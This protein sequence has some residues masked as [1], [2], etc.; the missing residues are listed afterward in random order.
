MGPIDFAVIFDMDGAAMP[1]EELSATR[2]SPG[3]EQT[4]R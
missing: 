1:L 3:Q 2:R 4:S